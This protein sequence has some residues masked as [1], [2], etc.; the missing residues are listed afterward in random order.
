[1]GANSKVRTIIA[2]DSGA[3][4]PGDSS[5]SMGMGASEGSSSL[6]RDI[7]KSF[8]YNPKELK[9][10]ARM[11]M[12]MSVSLGHALTAY[13]EFTRLKSAGISPDGMLGG[14]GYVMKVPDVRAKLQQACELLSAVS[15]TIHDEVNAPHWQPRLA[16]LGAN[17]AEDV[18]EYIHESEKILKDPEKYSEKDLDEVEERNDGPSGT[19]NDTRWGDT[20]EGKKDSGGASKLPGGGSKPAEVQPVRKKEASFVWGNSTVPVETLPGPRVDHLDR[21]EGQGPYGSYNDDEPIDLK[22]EWGKSEGVGGEYNYPSQWDGSTDAKYASSMAWGES[23]V[24]N[25]KGD[26]TE[27]E[28]NDFGLGYGAKGRGSEGYGTKAPDGRGVWGPSSGLPHDP[29]GKV[30]DDSE[31]SG[32]YLDGIERNMWAAS[33]LPFDGP[34]PVARSDYFPGPKGNL[35]D[36]ES[37]MPGDGVAD[38][39]YDKDTMNVDYTHEIQDVPYVKRDWS[40]HDDRHDQQDLYNYDRTSANG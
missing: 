22:D 13:R 12:A 8:T 14:R 2:S 1:M 27:T 32:P 21:G 28:A 17:D 24:P 23:S 11:L 29:G 15:D 3:L 6:R 19:S 18:T 33:D 38:Y 37:G 9:P 39:N 4:V 36:A 20:P 30:R 16:D 10:L 34:D 26:G 31:G 5:A 40:T 7:P 25:G 35:V